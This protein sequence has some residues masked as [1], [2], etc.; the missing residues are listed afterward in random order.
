MPIAGSL[1][2][3]V[4]DSV[5]LITSFFNVRDYGATGDGVTDDKVAV[6]AAIT[7]AVTAGGGTVYFPKGVYL[8]KS[9]SFLCQSSVNLLGANKAV[10]ILRAGVSQPHVLNA[11][12]LSPT[13]IFISGLTLDGN[14]KA[15]TDCFVIGLNAARLLVTDCIF[16]NSLGHGI[17][18]NGTAS[19][20]LDL[21]IIDNDFIAPI[22]GVAIGCGI[23]C[24]YTARITG[25]HRFSGNRIGATGSFGIGL[26]FCDEVVMSDNDIRGDDSGTF[27]EAINIDRSSKCRVIGNYCGHRGDCG[28]VVHTNNSTTL[29]CIGNI[30]IGNDCEENWNQGIAV[31]E[32]SVGTIVV[33]NHTRN[34]NRSAAGD[35]AEIKI[36]TG[37]AGAKP[38]FTLVEGNTLY[39]DQVGRSTM[40]VYIKNSNC[41]NNDIG[42]NRIMGTALVSPLIDAGLS[43][44]VSNTE[45]RS[46]LVIAPTYGVTVNTDAAL[47][48][49]FTVN[50]TNGVGFTIANPTNALDGETIT[51]RI[52]NISGGAMGVITWGAEFI[53]AGA[54]VNPANA[55]CRFITF[56]RSESKWREKSRTAADQSN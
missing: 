49:E 30:L 26:V 39:N 46:T 44:R 23:R 41:I 55:N 9:G 47:G 2:T 22:G 43:T 11:E 34:N 37:V 40:G 4:I 15:T 54:F 12:A 17:N 36:D 5:A 10:S 18:I 51:Y 50:A 21:R 52:A 56:R 33:G 29:P 7:A 16:K 45:R 32:F 8:T 14:L 19:G 25:R 20:P 38:Q 28:I 6:N 42:I 13:D 24:N 35:L 1:A 53:L 27:N 3:P 31:T 48:D